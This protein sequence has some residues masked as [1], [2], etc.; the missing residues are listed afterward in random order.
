MEAALLSLV[1]SRLSLDF[2]SSIVNERSLKRM[3]QGCPCR[4][5]ACLFKKIIVSSGG[6]DG[7]KINIGAVALWRIIEMAKP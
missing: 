7:A 5:C 3:P 1:A 2:R 6:S 4:D